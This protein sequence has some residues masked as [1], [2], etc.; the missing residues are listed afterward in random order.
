MH[1]LEAIGFLWKWNYWQL[2][3]VYLGNI[4]SRYLGGCSGYISAECAI[5]TLAQALT[6][7]ATA[8]NRQTRY[9][10]NPFLGY[11]VQAYWVSVLDNDMLDHIVVIYQQNVQ[12][13]PWYRP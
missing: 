3:K 12:Y 11:I 13:I 4:A 1:R 5:Y 10:F 8:A 9:I 2:C 7:A 6:R